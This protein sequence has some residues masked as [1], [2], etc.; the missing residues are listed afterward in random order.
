MQMVKEK[1]FVVTMSKCTLLLSS[2]RR[3]DQ[4]SIKRQVGPEL[5]S[6]SPT[7]L[8]SNQGDPHLNKGVDKLNYVQPVTNCLAGKK[9]TPPNGLKMCF[10]AFLFGQ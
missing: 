6:R 2:N 1:R 4:G 5:P 8:P 7:P 3:V 9:I 10:W